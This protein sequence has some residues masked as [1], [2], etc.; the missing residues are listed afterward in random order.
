MGTVQ[1]GGSWGEQGCRRH[2]GC[3]ARSWRHFVLGL[4]ADAISC[5][6]VLHKQKNSI[7]N[8]LLDEVTEQYWM[9]VHHFS[10][11]VLSRQ[12]VNEANSRWVF[13]FGTKVALS[14]QSIASGVSIK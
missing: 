2:E 9:S 7:I 6:D 3:E 5:D 8:F 14:A 13:S 12:F 11:K 1:E 4:M 10:L